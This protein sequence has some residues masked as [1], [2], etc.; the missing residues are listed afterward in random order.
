MGK[1]SKN[2]SFKV[3]KLQSFKVSKKQ[4]NHYCGESQRLDLET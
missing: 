3:S 2:K 1:V 4:R